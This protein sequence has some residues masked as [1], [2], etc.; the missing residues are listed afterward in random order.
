MLGVPAC[1]QG[2]TWAT[3]AAGKND[4]HWRALGNTLIHAGLANAVLRIGRE[5]NCAWYPWKVTEGDRS[6][7]IAGYSHVVSRLRSIPGAA[8]TFM[9]NPSIGVGNLNRSGTESCYPGD[10]VVDVIG[11]DFYDFANPPGIYPAGFKRTPAQ[12]QKCWNA[13]LTEWDG[14]TGWQAL[15]AHHKKPLAYP[16]WGLVL[17]RSGGSYLGG[18]DNPILIREM[19][20]WMKRNR[21]WMAAFWED[22]GMGVMDPDDSSSRLVAVPQSRQAFLTEFGY[23]S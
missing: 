1:G 17:W 8:F 2:S 13:Y 5:F 16:E 12:Q 10:D 23:G 21:P 22:T 3:E 20:R 15:A 9:W 7:Y 14:L 6:A 19:A 18:G 4:S 11:L